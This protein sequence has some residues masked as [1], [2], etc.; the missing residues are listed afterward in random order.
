MSCPEIEKIAQDEPDEATRAHL[1]ECAACRERLVKL[2]RVLAFPAM[3]PPPPDVLP[4]LLAKIDDQI[5]R[6]ISRPKRINGSRRA[7]AAALV[8]AAI[9]SSLVLMLGDHETRAK[10]HRLTTLVTESEQLAD[11]LGGAQ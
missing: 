1:A 11:A 4:K 9:G 6:E 7:L 2:E 8:F 10:E 3:T 5:A